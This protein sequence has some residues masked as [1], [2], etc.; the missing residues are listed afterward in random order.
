MYK[1]NSLDNRPLL[2]FQIADELLGLSDQAVHVVIGQPNAMLQLDRIDEGGQA[3][4]RHTREVV[5]KGA[6]SHHQLSNQL[7]L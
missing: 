3:V 4:N 1:N 7:C 2:R 5:F 6:L